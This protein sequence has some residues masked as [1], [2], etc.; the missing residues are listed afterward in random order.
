M[1]ND[2]PLS[3]W[4]I[5]SD[6]ETAPQRQT[7]LARQLDELD[8]TL[9]APASRKP[10]DFSGLRLCWGIGLR[11]AR[12]SPRLRVRAE[13][14]YR[15]LWESAGSGKHGVEETLLNLIGF[16]AD[17]DSIPFLRDL[18]AL[19][20]PRDTFAGDR[21]R[22][23]A[24]GLAYLAIHARDRAAIAVLHDLAEHGSPEERTEAVDALG[25]TVLCPG[26]PIDP[27]SLQVLE[28]VA[29]GDRVFA[30]RYLARSTL[31][32]HG[33]A[34]PAPGRDEL[35]TVEV[36][37]GRASRTIELRATATLHDLAAAILDALGWDHDHLYAFHMTGDL[38]DRRFVLDP[39]EG[40]GGLESLFGAGPG[41]EDPEGDAAA[42]VGDL[43]L[44]EFGFAAGHHIL[45][46]YDF[47]DDHRI[48]V[49]VRAVGDEARK[50]VEYPRVI[51]RQGAA[52]R[53]YGA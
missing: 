20:R 2:D 38:K 21:R 29:L 12:L 18:F 28:R 23:A 15:D 10:R 53:Q 1:R 39:S 6:P 47:G 52:P 51:E 13:A 41:E 4:L 31:L 48:D 26:G 37:Y 30:P 27:S 44:G 35:I 16:T 36:R 14:L 3:S 42:G 5:G 24:A 25:A 43:R 8:A 7:E 49:I 9:R 22:L 46:R 19:R 17:P 11:P 32:V 45:F 33:I 50:N 40:D 34:L